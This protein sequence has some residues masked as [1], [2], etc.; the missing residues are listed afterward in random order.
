VLPATI[1]QSIHLALEEAHSI[2]VIS[3][4]APDG[5]AISSLTA[6]GLAL[7]QLDKVFTLV[8]D[9]GLPERFR[10]LPLA[11]RV[12]SEPDPELDYDLIIALDAGDASRLGRAFRELPE[13]K[14]FLINIDHHITNLGY[15]QIDLVVPGANSTTEILLQL[16]PSL[17]VNLSAEMAVCLLSG[18]V[19][20]TLGFRTAGVNADT[21]RAASTLVDAGANLYEV[22]TKALTLKP[23]STLLNWQKGL[24][25]MRMEDGLLW[26]CISNAEREEAGHQGGSS[27]GLGNMM[28]EVY[29]A[30]VSAVMVEM[31]DG[32]ISVGFRC[33][34]PYSV[35]ELAIGLGGG[36]HHLAA[37][38]TVEGP[39]DE[40]VSLVVA[41]SK[42]SIRRQRSALK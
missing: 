21:L 40:A 20:D 11:A 37:G 41:R 8:C 7:E 35:S 31:P 4:I 1:V 15:G 2:M 25:N 26:T 9:D 19:T 22:T 36:G 29:Q 3:H 10:Y 14:P 23:L 39:L 6:T 5:D 34:P 12:I 38:C 30:P 13:P 24:N 33:R 17:G 16:F 32:Q 27:F 42:E 18:L 28:A